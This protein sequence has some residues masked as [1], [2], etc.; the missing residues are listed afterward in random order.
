LLQGEFFFASPGT[1]DG[2]DLNHIRTAERIPFD[3]KKLNRASALSQCVVLSPKSCVDQAERTE[4]RSIIGLPSNYFLLLSTRGSKSGPRRSRV[5]TNTSD[6]PFDRGRLQND[7][8][9]P[10][11][12]ARKR[13][14]RP[15]GVD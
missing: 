5:S 6:Q 1:D 2:E 15:I 14:E 9:Q 11:G 8:K 13:D 12:I 10:V 3:W 7:M 4:R